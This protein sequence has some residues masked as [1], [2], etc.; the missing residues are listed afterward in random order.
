MQSGLFSEMVLID[1]DRDRAEGEALDIAHG[2]PLAS[3]A[4]I[5]AGDY[6]DIAD[7]G[8]VIDHGGREP[9][10]R[11]DASRPGQQEREHLQ[12]DRAANHA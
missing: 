11:R 3:P 6:A 7:A 8:I 12:V 10:A 5:Y 9:K 1:V 4:N 2:M